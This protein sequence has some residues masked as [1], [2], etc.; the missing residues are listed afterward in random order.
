MN[1]Y[2]YPALVAFLINFAVIWAA[3]KGQKQTKVFV[4]LVMGFSFLNLCEVLIFLTMGSALIDYLIRAYY[5]GALLSLGLVSLYAAEVSE[6]QNKTLTYS[7][8][9]VIAT[10]AILSAC[11]D[12]VVVG[13]RSIEYSVTA[14]KGSGYIIF[15]AFSVGLIT[16]AVFMLIRGYRSA[17]SHQQ[18]IKCASTIV[19]ILPTV[20]ACLILLVLM[21]LG[22]RLNATGIIP[23]TMMAFILITLASEG[24]HKLTDIRRFIPGSV[25]RRS[26]RDVMDICTSYSRDE[27]SYRDAVS[28]IERVLV[29]HK[30]QKNDKN[31]SATAELMGMPRSSLYS[32]FNRL[33]IESKNR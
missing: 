10:F 7:V 27:I 30:Y 2:A 31:A 4:P 22:Y 9:F 28:Q 13:S 3:L 12:L 19:A 17:N 23:I 16:S 25:E 5:V 32:I 21:S 15:Q 18:Q 24:S 14:V 8:I 33:K 20:L 6:S 26:S 11:T 1:I 29:V